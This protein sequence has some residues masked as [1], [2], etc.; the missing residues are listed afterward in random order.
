[1]TK[2]IPTEFFNGN[3]IILTLS[4]SSSPVSGMLGM[5]DKGDFYLRDET[6]A[7]WPYGPRLSAVW[8]K[9]AVKALYLLKKAELSDKRPDAGYAR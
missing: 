4:E 5:T 2:K 7:W 1:M 9:R 6:G 8:R 3:H